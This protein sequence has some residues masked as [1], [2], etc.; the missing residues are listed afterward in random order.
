[1]PVCTCRLP[2]TSIRMPAADRWTVCEA[3]HLPVGAVAARTLRLR[4]DAVWSELQ[5]ACGTSARAAAECEHVHQLR[6]ATRRTLAALDA[7]EDVL[8]AK[9]RAWFQRRLV[10]LRRAAG[11]ARDL[12]VL[13]ARLSQP[14]AP[15]A[16]ARRRLVAMLS[17]QRNESREPIRE[18]REKLLESDWPGRVDG[19]LETLDRRRHQVAFGTYARRCFKPMITDFFQTADRRVRTASEMHALRIKGKKLRYALEI[20]SAVLPSRSG[21]KCRRSLERMQ[22]T[23][24]DFTDHAAAADR[25]ARW[26]RGADAGAS[27]DFLA[28]LRREESVQANLAR[29]EFAR[30]WNH[31]RRRSLRRRL[32]ST[33]K[34]SSA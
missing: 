15:A 31:D 2:P 18:I 13:T 8:P 11:E 24:G 5:A 14:D 29:R 12:D 16:L 34:R 10:R 23:L 19:L 28:A 7:F 33:I 20:F 27:R 1:M 26:A 30:W 22:R 32:E 4:L 21:D 25:F 6:V 17:R 9:R 3:V